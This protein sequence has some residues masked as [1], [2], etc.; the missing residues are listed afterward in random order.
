MYIPGLGKSVMVTTWFWL[1]SDPITLDDFM[2]PYE[3]ARH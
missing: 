3:R 2:T 1:I